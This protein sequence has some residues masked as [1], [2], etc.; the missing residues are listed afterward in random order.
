MK[1]PIF[2]LFEGFDAVGKST[3]IKEISSK[4]Q[5]SIIRS[6]NGL[7]AKARHYFDNESVDFKDRLA[8]YT[9]VAISS[10]IS[11]NIELNINNSVLMDRYFYSLIAYHYNEFKNLS[12]PMKKIY[13]NLC[14]PD[15]IFFIDLDYNTL[16]KRFS[17]RVKTHENDDDVFMSK[18]MYDTV[19]SAYKEILPREK[20]IFIQNIGSVQKVVSEISLHIP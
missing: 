7:F 17:E 19:T 18:K 12:E 6:P 4:H 3:L 1:K 13:K 14:Q 10:S 2:I 5:L 11:A 16:L 15:L 20:T 8:Y 9:G